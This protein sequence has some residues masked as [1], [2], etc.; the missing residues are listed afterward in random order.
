M[1]LLKDHTAYMRSCIKLKKLFSGLAIIAGRFLCL[2][3]KQTLNNDSWPGIRL[4]AEKS[5]RKTSENTNF[6]VPPQI[7]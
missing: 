4:D 6:Q 2:F 3:N 5:T 7:S 1:K